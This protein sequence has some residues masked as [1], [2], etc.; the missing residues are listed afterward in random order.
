MAVKAL[1][2]AAAAL[3]VGLAMILPVPHSK[4][5]AAEAASKIPTIEVGRG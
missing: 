2:A 1:F 3:A 4:E 5:S